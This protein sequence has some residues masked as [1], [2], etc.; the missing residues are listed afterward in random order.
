MSLG[1]TE[2]LAGAPLRAPGKD[3]FPGLLE[4]L[5]VSTFLGSWPLPLSVAQ[6]PLVSAP[7]PLSSPFFFFFFLKILFYRV[8]GEAEG[9]GQADSTLSAEPN[10][11][12][13]PTT[14]R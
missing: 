2:V 1:Y 6:H 11:G 14:L 10:V 7:S 4:L 5:M 13:E 3:Q 8:G 12:L 9:E